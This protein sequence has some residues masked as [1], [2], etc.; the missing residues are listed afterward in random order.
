[1]KIALSLFPLAVCA[2]RDAVS[3]HERLLQSETLKKRADYE[4]YLSQLAVFLDEIVHAYRKTEA[5]LGLPLNRFFESD[6]PIMAYPRQAE[7]GGG[8][9]R[10]DGVEISDPH[11]LLMVSSVRDAMLY[12]ESLLRNEAPP[13]VLRNQTEY[14]AHLARLLDS[15]KAEYRKV[16]S[17]VG[18]PL[19][20]LL[21]QESR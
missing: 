5:S 14:L 21:H 17:R 10:Q 1:M 12:R 9:G 11:S 3:F 4:E 15:I 18:V 13:E 16:E 2:A 8:Q 19:A 7:N 20:R 6:I